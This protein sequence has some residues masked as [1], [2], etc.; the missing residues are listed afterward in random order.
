MTTALRVEDHDGGIREIVLARPEVLNRFDEVLHH[1]L[2]DTLVR[3]AADPRV[4]SVVLASTG[5]AF[6][7]GGDFELMEQA[8]QDPAVRSRIVGDARR[9]LDSFLGLPQPIVVAVQGAAM[10]LGATVALACDAVV[11][12]HGATFADTH[13]NVGL[14]AGDGGCLVWPEAVGMVR[15]RRH[16]LTGEP[17]DAETAFALGAVSDL[18]ENAEEAYKTA[19]EIAERIARLAPLAVQG[20][21]RALNTVT[22][23]RAAEVV[24]LSLAYEERTL[25]SQDLLEGITAFRERRQ[26]SFR[27]M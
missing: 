18:A 19:R 23:R 8:R 10:G 27:G 1:E 17:L 26:P 11:A 15:A 4:R 14:V 25:G 22:G 2:T 9:L 7:A 24:D 13:V 6:S 21:K 20:T 5:K 12:S 3:T 16:L